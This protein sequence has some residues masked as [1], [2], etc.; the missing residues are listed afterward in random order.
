MYRDTTKHTNIRT[1]LVSHL[2]LTILK[3]GGLAMLEILSVYKTR[4]FGAFSS[5]E[6]VMI[7]GVSYYG[8]AV[9]D[10]IIYEGVDLYTGAKHLYRSYE[11]WS[12]ALDLDEYVSDVTCS[13]VN[14]MKGV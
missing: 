4:L 1:G 14:Y 10:Y 11:L 13:I 5:K 8:D 3:I 12:D 7:T 9:D 6:L 2:K